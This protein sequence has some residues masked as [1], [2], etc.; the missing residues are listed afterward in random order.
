MPSAIVALLTLA[1]ALAGRGQTQSSSGTPAPY[2]PPLGAPALPTSPLGRG[3]AAAAGAIEGARAT[4]PAVAQR[5]AALYL[6]AQQQAAAGDVSGA[7]ATTSLA[8]VAALSASAAGPLAPAIPFSAAAS[9]DMRSV[10]LAVGAAVLPPEF[11]RVRASLE[12]ASAKRHDFALALAKSHYRRA[13]D[14]YLS[15]DLARARGDLRAAAA[16]VT[17]SRMKGS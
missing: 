12:R 1:F 2:V 8:R 5:A 17:G 13:L 6:R 9:I 16:L 11:L 3:L 7:L 15:G 4:D 14:A 10:P